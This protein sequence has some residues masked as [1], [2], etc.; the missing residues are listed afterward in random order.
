VTVLYGSESA[1]SCDWITDPDPDPPLFFS[2]FQDANKKHFFN[3]F[4]ACYT[5]GIFTSLFK[6][7]KLTRS[8]RTVEIKTSLHFFCLLMGGSGARAGPIQIIADPDPGGAKTYNFYGFGSGT[9]VSDSSRTFLAKIL[10]YFRDF[11]RCIISF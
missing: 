11:L 3:V 10:I 5:V 1:D 8:H 9:L 4:L 2:D 6:D 7:N